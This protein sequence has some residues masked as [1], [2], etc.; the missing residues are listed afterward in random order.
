MEQTEQTD[1]AI[2]DERAVLAAQME[3]ERRVDA[4]GMTLP[5]WYLAQEAKDSAMEEMVRRQAERII[6]G[7]NARRKAREWRWGSEF[8]RQ[9]EQDM[10]NQKGK[11]K[12][13]NYITGTAG[14][15]MV[16]GKVHIIDAAALKDWAV[17]NLPDA[18][19]LDL[20]VTPIRKHIEESGE[21]PP[22]A[23]YTPPHD[24]FYP[25]AAGPM[26]GGTDG[27][28]TG[29]NGLPETTERDSALG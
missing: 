8:R 23:E 27:P 21:V 11:K 14:F 6:A 13:V 28:Q 2:P 24:K 9:V 17:A 25:A 4:H 1:L 16:P 10:A 19:S 3:Q 5:E 18:L 12:S 22:G 7:I 20:H 15:R 29:A 26:L